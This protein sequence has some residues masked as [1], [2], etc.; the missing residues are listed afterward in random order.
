MRNNGNQKS[1]ASLGFSGRR[2]RVALKS[3]VFAGLCVASLMPLQASAG[4]YDFVGRWMNSEHDA[5]GITGMTI[6]PDRRGLNVRIFGLCP[7]QD[8]CD[9]QVAHADLYATGDRNWGGRNWGGGNWGGFSFNFG[10]W[11]NDTDVVTAEV[12]AGYAR[13]FIVLKRGGNDELRAEIFTTSRDRSGRPGYFTETRFKK[14]GRM[15]GFDNN[16]YRD[17]GR[18]DRYRQDRYRNQ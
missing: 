16:G 17:N 5:S 14:W 8:V 4:T 11:Q 9:W 2:S 6:T 12:D 3:V 13:K 15:P 10:N 7:G 1:T 18:N